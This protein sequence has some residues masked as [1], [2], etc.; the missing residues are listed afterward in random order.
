[1][2][3]DFDSI[4][5]A[6]RYK[7]LVGL[8]VPRPIAL[9]TSISETGVVNA[10]PY[11]FFN[12]LGDDPPIVIVSVDVRGDGSPKDTARNILARREFVVNLV[13]EAIAAPMHRCAEPFPPEVSEPEVVGLSLAPSQR[14]AVPRLA[15]APVALEC[16]LHQTV[17]IDRRELIIGRVRWLHARDGIVDP[18]TLRVIPTQYRPI[19]RFYGNRYCRT[20]D[21]FTVE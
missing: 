8:V 14:V 10:A 16:T 11:S 15:E 1:M 20:R 17:P 9:V 6:R 19:G 21:Q 7:L 4:E 2:Y 3:W 13:D 5:P 18:E 12:V